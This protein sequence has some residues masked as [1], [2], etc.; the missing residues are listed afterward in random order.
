MARYAELSFFYMGYAAPTAGTTLLY[1]GTQSVTLTF[2]DKATEAGPTPGGYKVYQDQ[3]NSYGYG[4]GNANATRVAQAL[5]AAL[6]QVGYDA[7][8]A[9]SA[10][11]QQLNPSSGTQAATT[12]TL[13]ATRWGD[14]NNFDDVFSYGWTTYSSLITNINPQQVTAEVLGCACFGSSTGSVLLSVTGG[15]G[16]YTYA[17][18]DNVTTA[19]RLN[20]PAGSY[21]VTVT[22]SAAPDPADPET[23][24]VVPGVVML[25][26]QV[27]QNPRLEVLIQKTDDGVTLVASGGVG[28]YTYTW[29]DGPAGPTRQDLAAGSYTCRITDA[30][31]CFT[32]VVVAIEPYRYY[33]V[34]N[35]I[36]LAVDAGDD[37]RDDPS[38]KPG[39]TFTC[40]VLVEREY[41]S[42][43]FE[44]VGTELEQPAD[45][46]GRT[47]FQVQALLA[48]FLA[49][50]V[51]PAAGPVGERATSLF[52]RFFL[53][54]AEVS[55]TPPVRGARTSMVQHYATLGGLSYAEA[56]ARTWFNSYQ[57]GVKPFL[58][59]EPNDK[60]V[61]ADQPEFLYF[62]T[63]SSTSELYFNLRAEFADGTSKG[64]TLYMLEGVSRFEVFCF[65]VG[66]PVVSIFLTPAQQAQVVGWQVEVVD[67]QGTRIS[68]VRRYVLD[69]R[70]LP[71]RRYLLYANSLGG[72]NTFVATGEAQ[73]EVAVSGTQVEL[74]RP[75]EYDLLA[76]DTAVLER[77]LTPVLK[78]ASGLRLDSAA[79]LG[80][81]ELLL[82][83]R[84]LL[85]R[86]GRWLPG[87]VKTKTHTLLDDGQPVPTLDVE[88]VLPAE[89]QFT[90]YL[91]PTPANTTPAPVSPLSGRL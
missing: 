12:I 17:W 41:L 15:V 82:T 65:A 46:Q 84:A 68:E 43:E 67:E 90:P 45:R 42:G 81:Q 76:G 39:L 50:H 9:V 75:L 14:E 37:Y 25:T 29:D 1:V 58:T 78:L 40:Q 23:A 89:Q 36:P 64:L 3:S 51:P 83:R 85:L 38:T 32:D 87:Y 8:V 18:A 77:K 10:S 16:P 20:V 57:P 28:P 4:D 69:R 52:K 86:Q 47:T 44:P 24:T 6:A 27:G 5:R 54:Y 49:P 30:K 59:W 56:Q 91:P 53:R 48:P 79:K 33:F 66:Y 35:P 22:D 11:F 73:H 7:R 19:D 71:N 21:L 62:Q 80:L 63:T 88:F 2:T 70:V 26:V 72:M 61:L 74:T 34:R 31:A 13:K 60:A 55:G